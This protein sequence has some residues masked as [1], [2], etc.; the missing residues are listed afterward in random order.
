MPIMR[1]TESEL[2]ADTFD[3]VVVGSG[4]GGL[5]TA[6][7][8]ALK[9]LSVLVLEKDAL[10]GGTTARSGGVLW[11]P[12]NGKFP[13]GET[14][15]GA[16]AHQYLRQQ[17]GRAYDRA[18]ISAFAAP[19]DVKERT[20]RVSESRRIIPSSMTCPRSLRSSA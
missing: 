16:D 3:V 10:Y 7:T 15:A 17:T 18:R 9:G 8:A 5:A 1:E 20:N 6:V 13:G 4:A 19:P 11:I 14:P 12:G 2:I